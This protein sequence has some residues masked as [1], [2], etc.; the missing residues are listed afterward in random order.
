MEK[1]VISFVPVVHLSVFGEESVE[2]SFEQ[3][4]QSLKE[5]EGQEPEG[6][7]SIVRNKP[8][9]KIRR[10]AQ[11]EDMVAF[12]L[13]IIVGVPSTHKDVVK[14]SDNLRW[15]E[16]MNEEM[17]SLEKNQS[18]ELVHRPKGKK[19]TGCKW[20]M[21]RKKIPLEFATRPN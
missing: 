11:F 17:K 21:Q 15:R 13:L 4:E 18:W 1:V 3:V 12:G 7:E 14:C 19:V 8:Q 9:R 10:L 20:C 16:A 5:D 6:P 2:E